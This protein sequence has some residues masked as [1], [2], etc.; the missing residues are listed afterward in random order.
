MIM[1]KMMFIC[2]ALFISAQAMNAAEESKSTNLRLESEVTTAFPNEVMEIP[3][4]ENIE[5][6]ETATYHFVSSCGHPLDKTTDR[7]LTKD[8]IIAIEDAIE[9]Q[10]PQ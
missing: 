3:D 6:C 10:C 8:E 5:E 7:E 4:I 1:K 9:R 2:A